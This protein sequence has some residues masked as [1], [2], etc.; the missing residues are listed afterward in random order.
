M[1]AGTD[2]CGTGWQQFQ[3]APAV[4]RAVRCGDRGALSV[5]IAPVFPAFF[6]A[7]HE[8]TGIDSRMQPAEERQKPTALVSRTAIAYDTKL[9]DAL[10][11]RAHKSFTMRC[12]KKLHDALSA[13]T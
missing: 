7:P 5:S 11:V 13:R 1:S 9:H 6:E 2:T 10:S 3:P 4:G 8:A 12:P